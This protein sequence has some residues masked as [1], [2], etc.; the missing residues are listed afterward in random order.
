MMTAFAIVPCPS[1]SFPNLMA[2]VAASAF[3]PKASKVART[4]NRS[5]NMAILWLA[6]RHKS[7][8]AAP[9]LAMMCADFAVFTT[10]T[11]CTGLPCEEFFVSRL[12]FY[13]CGAQR[14]AEGEAPR[15]QSRPNS[16]QALRYGV[17][18]G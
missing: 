7:I 16:A 3:T 15:V 17:V 5:R 10:I 2:L 4:A 9:D 6:K 1:H 11:N 13:F 14:R 12:G 8:T 18:P